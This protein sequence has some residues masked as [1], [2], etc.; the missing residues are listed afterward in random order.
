MV[1]FLDH[2]VLFVANLGATR[3]FY[4]R[5]LGPLVW[6][7]EHSLMYVVGDTRLFFATARLLDSTFDK[8]RV[9]LNHLTFGVRTL[10]ELHQIATHLDNVGVRHSGIQI[11]HY[12]QKE[13]VW[14]DDPDGLRVEFYL[15]PSPA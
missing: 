5:L 2:I 3:D 8:E 1:Q 11:D 12:G 4:N 10:E 7:D 15:R 9:G 14:L 6:S 13:F